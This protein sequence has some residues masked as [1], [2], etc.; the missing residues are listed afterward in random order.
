MLPWL[1][2]LSAGLRAGR[3]LP[4]LWREL[5]PVYRERIERE[6]LA[7]TSRADQKPP[8]GDWL[9]WLLLGG[10]GAGK[11][12]SGAEWVRAIATGDAR[13]GQGK[14]GRIALVGETFADVREVMIEGVSGVLAVHERRER[15]RWYP[16]RRLLVWDSGVRA[17][18]FS[19]EDPE[20][21]RGP[22]FGAAWA[23]ELAKW[24]HAEMVWD[25]LQFGLRLGERPRQVVT[26]TPRPTPLLRRLA[27]IN[28]TI[29]ASV[30]GNALTLAVKT[31]AGVNPSAADPVYI[32]FRNATAASGDFTV[33]TLSAA[34]SL[35]ISSGSTL[36]A[37]SG[38]PFRLWVVG[39]NDGGTF[40]LGAVKCAATGRI[41]PLQDD[42]L[43]SATAEGGS[44]SAD[45]AGVIYAGAAVSSKA[46]RILGY[47]EWSAGLAT[48]GTWASAPTKVQ[49]FG[50]GIC[51]PGEVVQSALGTASTAVTHTNSGLTDTGLAAT[52]TPT[53]AANAVKVAG[54]NTEI[55]PNASGLGA[56]IKLL[57]GSTAVLTMSSGT[58]GYGSNSLGIINVPF[59]WLDFP[60]TT[61]ATTYKTQA[62]AGNASGTVNSQHNGGTSVIL[63]EEIMA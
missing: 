59:F 15:P 19:S 60:G 51:K 22:Q 45:S 9:T 25:M 24:R 36:G 48:A 20:G 38:A 53:S 32:C 44:G 52:L 3:D 41:H 4:T 26:T 37:V 46:L 28:G 10:R 8:E 39:F 54:T 30:S 33:L 57:R 27:L 58:I 31:L 47:A 18:A 35:V 61:S 14:V 7:Y 13:L 43:A 12:R 63:A 1:N 34:T 17:Q 23:D 50:P 5:P 49:L 16:A 2:E 42:A 6:W 11:T 40:R 56:Q 62:A 29:A 55:F 21:L